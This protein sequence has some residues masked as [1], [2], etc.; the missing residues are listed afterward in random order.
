MGD[1][2]GK[3]LRGAKTGPGPIPH[4]NCRAHQFHN[5]RVGFR[6]SEHYI[7]EGGV[8]AHD[9]SFQGHCWVIVWLGE[10]PSN[11]HQDSRQEVNLKVR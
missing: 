7:A 9:G 11:R 3:R 4:C 1:V 8:G 6:P 10:P 5:A 2:K